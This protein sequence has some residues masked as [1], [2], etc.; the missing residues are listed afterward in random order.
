MK[1]SNRHD[2]RETTFGTGFGARLL[3]RW[4]ADNFE[5]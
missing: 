4:I 2:P 3:N 1:P 5:G